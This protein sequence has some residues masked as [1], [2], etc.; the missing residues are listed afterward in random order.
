MCSAC[1]PV[2]TKYSE[3]K[4]CAWTGSRPWKVKPAPG[5]SPSSNL[6][7]YSTTLMPRNTTPRTMVDAR[8][9]ICLAR[10]PVCA[11]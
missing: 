2:M 1:M 9:T 6:W 7:L 3:K 8:Y 10:F 4:S 5:T 11:A